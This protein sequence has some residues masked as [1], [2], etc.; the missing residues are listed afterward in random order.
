[1]ILYIL[2]GCSTNVVN[3]IGISKFIFVLFLNPFSAKI[4]KNLK[5]KILTQRTPLARI[6][7]P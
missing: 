3:R 2:D 5:K 4:A 1:M 6:C 7:N